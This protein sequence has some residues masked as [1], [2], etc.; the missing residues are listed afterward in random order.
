MKKKAND[1]VALRMHPPVFFNSRTATVDTLLPR[2][3]GEDGT[4]PLLIKKDTTIV[5]NIYALHHRQDIYGADANEYKPERWL[6]RNPRSAWSEQAFSGGPRTCLG[7]QLALTEA[8]YLL[9]QL[10]RRFERVGGLDRD[11]EWKETLEFTCATSKGTRVVF[12]Y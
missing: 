3:G 9:Y 8:G 1:N 6:Q 2:G 5:S 7:Q 12:G 4:S 11:E 10:A